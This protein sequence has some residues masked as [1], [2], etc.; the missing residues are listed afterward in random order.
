VVP[1]QKAAGMTVREEQGVL[2]R[3]SGRQLRD[4]KA[5]W[6]CFFDIFNVK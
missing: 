2:T 5:S 1:R 3:K 4:A 6:Q